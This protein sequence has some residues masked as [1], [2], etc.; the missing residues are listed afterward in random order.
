MLSVRPT[1]GRSTLK[2]LAICGKAGKYVSRASG[3]KATVMARRR[4]NLNGDKPDIDSALLFF[5]TCAGI[6]PAR[7]STLQVFTCGHTRPNQS[8]HGANSQ[9]KTPKPVSASGVGI[10][11]WQRPTLTRPMPD[12]HRRRHASH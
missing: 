11:A 3:P 5:Q 8:Q 9:K 1:A 6:A 10:N 2:S 7:N 12:Y 4:A